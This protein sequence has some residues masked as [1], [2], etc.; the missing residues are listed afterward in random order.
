MKMPL[1]PHSGPISA[2]GASPPKGQAAVSGEE[3][4]PPPASVHVGRAGLWGRRRG[5]KGTAVEP[6]ISEMTGV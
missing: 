4:P 3:L 5:P 2:G 1:L 6:A